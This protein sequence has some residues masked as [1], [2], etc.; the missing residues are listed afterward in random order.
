[1][2]GEKRCPTCHTPIKGHPNKRFCNSKCKDL[3]HNKNNPRGYYAH[4]NDR[5]MDEYDLMRMID[6]EMH[7]RDSYSL[8]QS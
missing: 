5:E 8:G 6:D 2:S 7:P 4:L 3:Y 1:M